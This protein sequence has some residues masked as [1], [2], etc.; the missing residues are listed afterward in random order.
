MAQALD[1]ARAL[2]P[3]RGVTVCL[4]ATAGQG[5]C[6]GHQLEHLAGIRARVRQPA[7]VGFCLD[8]AHLFAAGHD[9][10][11]RRYAGF[12]KQ[13][14]KVLGVG[15]VKVL[16]LN[17]TEKALGSRVDRHAHP[18]EGNIGAAGLGPLVRDARF[19]DVP[20]IIETPQGVAPDG[21]DRDVYNVEVLRAWA[22][23]AR[24]RL[25]QG[26]AEA[27]QRPRRGARARVVKA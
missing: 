9:F 8:T 16:H 26:D 12:I 17:D 2:V 15:T 5:S 7:R 13:V 25:G 27:Q 20:K 22:R 3:A 19:R 4:E 10:R 21:G 14:D 1:R 23:S 24:K 6:V 18:G 11:G